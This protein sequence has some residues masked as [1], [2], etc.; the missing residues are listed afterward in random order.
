MGA[1]RFGVATAGLLCRG[2]VSGFGQDFAIA[3]GGGNRWS[4][5]PGKFR[6]GVLLSMFRSG[7]KRAVILQR[8]GEMVKGSG[9]V[10]KGIAPGQK[11]VVVEIG[12][13][14]RTNHRG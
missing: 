5:E 9:V 1:G 14:R 2:A 7:M 6:E 3:D 4:C 10:K 12:G 8:C 13:Q 11:P